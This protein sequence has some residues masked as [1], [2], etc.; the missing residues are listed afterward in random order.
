MKTPDLD[1]NRAYP[2][3]KLKALSFDS[4]IGFKKKLHGICCVRIKTG[5][6]KSSEANYMF[7]KIK[8]KDT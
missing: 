1:S 3:Y 2:R 7:R 8:G 4:A 6:M 5:R